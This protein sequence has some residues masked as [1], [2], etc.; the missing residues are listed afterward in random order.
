MLCDALLDALPPD[1]RP[2]L[3]LE[4]GR[5]LVDEAGH[6]VTSVVAAKRLADGTRAYVL[7]AGVNLLYTS[8]WYK[9]QIETVEAY[10]GLTEPCVLYGP[11]C[12]NIDLVDDGLQ[13]P[14][15]QRGQQLVEEWYVLFQ[16]LDWNFLKSG[17][18]S[19]H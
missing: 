8:T 19:S 4:S 18:E 7:D 2:K 15:L 5:A 1:W 10:S 14:P 9:F 3:I 6:L 17:S 12:M 16:S 13:L 11:L